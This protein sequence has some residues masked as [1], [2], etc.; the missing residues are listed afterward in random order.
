MLEFAQALVAGLSQ[1]S[2]YALMALGLTIV[3]RSTTILNFSHGENFMLGAFFALTMLRAWDAPYLIVIV[4]ALVLVFVLS[5][6]IERIAIEPLIERDHLSQVF[7]TVALIYILR[8][9]VRYFQIDQ[10]PLDPILGVLPMR[11]GDVPINK[12][13]LVTAGV[14][15]VITPLLGLLFQRTTLGRILR[16]T[17]QNLRGASLVGINT[18]GV[19]RMTWAA[20]AALGALAGILAG[21]VVLV[22][23]GMGHRPLILAFAAMTV[24]G[25]GSIPGAIVGGLFVGLVEVFAGVYVSTVLGDVA[26]YALIFIILLL[27][28]QGLLGSEAQVKDVDTEPAEQPAAGQAAV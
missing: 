14:L 28:P 1:G 21:P 13:Y 20:A 25:F 6:A 16:A 19:F 9:V 4:A 27:R 12:Q 5:L 2:I 18:R 8:G 7:A 23:A 17:T 22:S 24:G 10:R 15:L 11:I 3:Y 26:G